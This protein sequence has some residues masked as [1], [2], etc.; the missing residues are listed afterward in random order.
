MEIGGFC[1]LSEYSVSSGIRRIEA[2][3]GE[4][5]YKRFAGYKELVSRTAEL[6]KTKDDDIFS[7]IENL[8]SALRQEKDRADSLEKKLLAFQVRG[9]IDKNQQTICG[10]PTIILTL[11]DKTFDHLL[12]LSDILREKIGSGLVLLVSQNKDSSIFVFSLTQ[13]LEKRKITVKDFVI[14]YKGA[15]GLR[16]GGRPSLCQG[17]IADIDDRSAYAGKLTESLR[18]YLKTCA[19]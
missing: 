14:R 15:L 7:R 4:E 8:Q 9:L 12:Y 17:Q 6:L 10:I 18:E 5:A 16:G 1:V 19:S 2:L 11:T 3:V 13:D